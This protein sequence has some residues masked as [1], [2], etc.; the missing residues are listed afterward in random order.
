[1]RKLYFII[2]YLIRYPLNVLKKNNIHKST[3]ISSNT[4]IAKSTI[5]K[6]CYIANNINMVNVIMGN[7]CSIAP[8]V[9][10][11]GMEHSYWWYSMSTFLSDKCISNK[12]TKIG[13]DV[14]IAA[15]AIIKQGVTIGDGAVIG[16]MS[17]VNKDVPAY[18]VVIGT[19]AKILKYR[20]DEKQIKNLQK[21]EYWKEKPVL[22][23]QILNSI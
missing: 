23:K 16:A 12:K 3:R 6:Y 9:Q 18:A 15:G 11:G 2:V 21:T 1:M 19:P 22:A 14:W 20:F 5:G 7:Y 13:N 10:I 4:K 17:F 8:S